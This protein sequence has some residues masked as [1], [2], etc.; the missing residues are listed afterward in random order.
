M[1]DLATII[2]GL[3]TVFLILFLR[4]MLAKCHQK[5]ISIEFNLTIVCYIQKLSLSREDICS[6]Q[7]VPP[8]H[9]IGCN[10]IAT[11]EV[12]RKRGKKIR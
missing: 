4:D 1:R 8:L 11:V 6:L 2:F 10:L 9:G 5:A 12:K 7:N 3:V